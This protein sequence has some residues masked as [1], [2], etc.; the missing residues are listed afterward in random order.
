VPVGAVFLLAI[1]LSGLLAD[2]FGRVFGTAFVAG[3]APGVTYT[4]ERCAQLLSF[5][6]QARSCEEAAIAHH[7]GEVVSYRLAAGAL[8]VLVLAGWA[9][10]R[11]RT[12][13]RLRRGALGRS[14]ALTV[15]A[16]LAAAAAAALL[17]LG[18]A[19][20]ITGHYDGTGNPLSGGLVSAL[21]A[22]IFAVALWRE[23]RVHRPA[24]S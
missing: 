20:P 3:D 18:A 19:G 15:G 11:R 13:E 1:G 14:F 8:G 10:W 6:P 12:R 7:F 9:V 5:E 16:A 23:L 22:G 17:F 21:L 4:A 24:R 2:T